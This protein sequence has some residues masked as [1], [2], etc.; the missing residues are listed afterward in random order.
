MTVHITEHPTEVGQFVEQVRL[1]LTDLDPEEQQDLVS[2][3]EADLGDL[4]AERGPEALGDPSTY[5][6]ELRVAAGHSPVMAPR[7]GGRSFRDAVT[8]AID[9]THASWDRLLD[10][11]PGDL[12]GFLTALQPAWWVL[13]A[14]VAWLVVQ[15]I[16]GN[17]IAFNLPWL[18]GLAVFLVVSV[19]IGRRVWGVARLLTGSVATRLLLVSL[20]VF[21]LTMLPGAVDRLMWRV[22]DER[23]TTY[24]DSPT[25]NVITYLGGQVCDIEVRKGPGRVV[26]DAYVWDV[27]GDRALPMHN[28]MC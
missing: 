19:Q 11:L 18:F 1:L 26:T 14:C 20:N 22:A 9:S 28:E 7:P 16:R 5:A 8:H 15:D 17:Y 12:R 25:G 3:L 6:R 24:D 23:A 2:G 13:R 4:V 10:S 27:T 21:A